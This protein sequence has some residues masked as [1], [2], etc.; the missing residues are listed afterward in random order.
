LAQEPSNA[1]AAMMAKGAELVAR[2]GKENKKLG[3]DTILSFSSKDYVFVNQEGYYNVPAVRVIDKKEGYTLIFLQP[4]HEVI[5][6]LN[7][8]IFDELYDLPKGKLYDLPPSPQWTPE[9]AIEIG[10]R[11]LPLIFDR[12]DVILGEPKAKYRQ[13]QQTPK[14]FT[15]SWTVGWP[16]VDREGRLFTRIEDISM[17]ISE[18][19]GLFLFRVN[20]P[21]TYQE[22]S[23]SVLKSDDVLVAAQKAA[24]QTM[25]WAPVAEYFR[26]G[27]ID[28]KP[29]SASLG[30]VT[31]NHLLTSKEI[32]LKHDLNARLAW[33]FA[34]AWHPNDDPKQVKPI[35]VWID[36]HTGEYL[37]GDVS[38]SSL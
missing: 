29:H 37:G 35:W 27:Q 25:T 9:H 11:F 3:F 2:I 38:I 12:K 30:V 7:D 36:A 17:E 14:Y 23:G 4:N 8:R 15:G 33:I 13:R 26:D 32:L 1:D 10:K 19:R 21:S 22:E 24:T 18:E 20:L 28:P 6:F 16:R 31:P 34:F 5:S